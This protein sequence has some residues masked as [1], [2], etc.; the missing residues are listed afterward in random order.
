M[1][2]TTDRP[3]AYTAR[4]ELDARTGLEDLVT[5]SSNVAASDLDLRS[6]LELV[7]LMNSEDA[8]VPGAV[9]AAAPALAAAVD[10]IVPRLAAGGRLVYV[11]AG[12]S[13]R[14]AALDADECESTF[15]TPPG[16]VI[17][18]VAGADATSAAGRDAAEDDAD[19][20]AADVA[21]A[22]V[23]SADAV[24]AISASGRTPYVLGAVRAAADAGA[25]TVA[26][27]CVEGSELGDAVHHEVAA[28]V[29]PEVIA[30]STRLKAGTA[31]KLVLNTLSTAAM[32]RLGR[33]YGN[34]MVDVSATNDKLR[35]R[36]HR[37]VGLATGAAD[38]EVAAALEAADG[39]AK[40][41]I[42]ML[43][44]QLDAEAARARLAAA[45]GNVRAALAR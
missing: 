13:G 27:V 21:R 9:G 35:A 29:G 43:S 2:L 26:V 16:Q 25:L 39:S 6:T 23:T 22:G 15:S 11:G 4:V 14:L 8:G 31:Q 30:G 10:A 28:V 32:V 20:G 7:Q 5:E 45:G 41:A 17:A 36:A 34:L 42:V 44:A 40:V 37:V 1:V 18:L 19:A 33:T 24:V 3:D 38:E 12:T